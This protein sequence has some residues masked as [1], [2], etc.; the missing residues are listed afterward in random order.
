MTK[1]KELEVGSKFN[2]LTVLD[3]LPVD[4]TGMAKA[5]VV[6]DCGNNL[7]V[8]NK[9]LKNGNTKSCGCLKMEK[10]LERSTKHGM[11]RTRIYKIWRHMKERCSDESCEYY[12][13]YGG[14]GITYD[15]SWKLF[16]N[17]YKDMFEFYREDLE[18]DRIDVNGNYCK[19]NCRWTNE[20][21]QAYNQRKRK[22]NTSGRTG[23]YQKEDGKWWAEI[24]NKGKTEW[25]GTFSTFEDACEA[26][27]LK[28][29]EYYGYSKE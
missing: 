3:N 18:L 2:R 20:S 28:E 4:G 19:E 25:L 14:R 8:A 24:Q 11:S 22:N 21:E 17:F 23:V 10:L 13:D 7:V 27:E 16:E 5:R 26:R 15:P 6:C 29:L 9:Y 12:K 1:R